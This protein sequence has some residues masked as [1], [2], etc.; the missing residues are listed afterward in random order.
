MQ[1]ATSVLALPAGVTLPAPASADDPLA[2]L[3][4]RVAQADARATD[5][6]ALGRALHARAGGA[7]ERM[8]AAL[9]AFTRAAQLDPFADPK[10]MH[11]LAQ[12]AFVTREWPLVEASCAML[13]ERDPNDANALVWRSAAAQARNDFASAE[14]LL[15]AAARIVPNHPVVL[16]KL[17]LCVK[18]QT[19]FAEGEALLREVLALKPRNPHARFDLSELELRSGRYA[20]GWEDYEA[21]L[22]L[23]GDGNGARTALASIGAPWQGES[24]AGRTLVVYGEQGNGDCLWAFRFLAPLAERARREGG[25]V[26]LGY[27]GPMQHLFERMLPPG[28][29]LEASLATHPDY[30]CGLMSL[31]LRLGVFDPA[32]WGA[33]YL[34]ADPARVQTWRARVAQAT[35]AGERSV[36]LVW[37]GNPSHARD[38]RRSIPDAELGALFSVP[39]LTF[40]ALSPGRGAAVEAWRARGANCVDLTA[41]FEAGFDDVAAL[42]ASVDHV[43]TIDSGPAHLAGA[44]GAPTSLLIDHVSAWFWGSETARMP[45]YDSIELFRQPAVGE[46]GPVLARVRARL[47]ALAVS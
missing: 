45:W 42:I 11:E 37:N 40:F 17:A 38:A 43:V 13:L 34:R 31:P 3:L 6:L 29:A 30:H 27:A 46:W 5:W 2:P 39:G 20:Q 22:E 21:R 25:R 14:D 32:G 44:L 15:R 33:S 4:A 23:D 1:G 28:V 41:Q 35:P 36:A 18:E 47:E 8:R 7:V 26:V 24:L 12:T 19:R 9:F 10:L 16:H